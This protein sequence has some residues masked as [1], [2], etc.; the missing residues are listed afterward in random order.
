MNFKEGDIVVINLDDR[1]LY[2][3]FNLTYARNRLHGQIGLVV[4]INDTYNNRPA[5]LV[6]IPPGDRNRTY[7]ISPQMLTFPFHSEQERILIEVMHND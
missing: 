7:Y 2:H 4:G 5:L 1:D 6:E 3:I